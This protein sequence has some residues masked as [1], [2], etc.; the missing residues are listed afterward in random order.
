MVY[1]RTGAEWQKVIIMRNFTFK[2]LE[3]SVFKVFIRKNVQ[4]TDT[5]NLI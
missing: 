4:E 3:E 1:D 2:K 5:F